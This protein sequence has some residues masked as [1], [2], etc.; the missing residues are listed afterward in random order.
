M[1]IS[2]IEEE[3]LRFNAFSNNIFVNLLINNILIRKSKIKILI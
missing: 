1:I 2:K 3:K